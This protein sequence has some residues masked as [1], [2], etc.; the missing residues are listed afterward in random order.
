MRNNKLVKAV[1]FG[2]ALILGLS[3]CGEVDAS[4]TDIEEPKLSEDFTPEDYVAKAPEKLTVYL[5]VD[6]HPTL[7]QLCIDGVAFRTISSLH[8][9]GIESGAVA[10]VPEWD[11]ECPAGTR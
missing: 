4:K 2:A 3:A 6:N 11:D 10:R 9:G 1:L 8:S 5:N 7:V